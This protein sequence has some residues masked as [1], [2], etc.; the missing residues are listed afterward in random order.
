M[1]SWKSIIELACSKVRSGPVVCC[2]VLIRW[3]CLWILLVLSLCLETHLR[4][5]VGLIDSLDHCIVVC[6]WL[7]VYGCHAFIR[8]FI[9]LFD[10]L[11]VREEGSICLVPNARLVLLRWRLDCLCILPC[12]RKGISS[13][14]IVRLSLRL[15]S[16]SASLAW[17]ITTL[18]ICFWRLWR[19]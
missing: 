9:I 2:I 3:R 1:E 11:G 16:K 10:Y 6:L 13:T 18:C 15:L 4:K 19:H 14:Y 17:D 12:K 7:I 8:F 5:D